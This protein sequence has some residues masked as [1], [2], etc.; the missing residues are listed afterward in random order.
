M[1]K[2]D[3][4]FVNGLP[5]QASDLAI[6]RAIVAMAKSLGL[7]T[8]VEG[9]EVEA[10]YACLSREEVTWLQGFW[11]SHPLSPNALGDLVQRHK[12]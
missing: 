6:V 5:N 12:A 1:L 10:Q 3:K 11:Y 9:V 7:T 8:V 2:I 4:S